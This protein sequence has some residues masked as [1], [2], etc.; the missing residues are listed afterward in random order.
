M[1][2]Q[3]TQ[4]SV[5]PGPLGGEGSSETRAEGVL[6]S[7]YC[8]GLLGLTPFGGSWRLRRTLLTSSLRGR[9]WGIYPLTPISHWSPPHHTH[10]PP[11]PQTQM[12]SRVL[13][14]SPQSPLRAVATVRPTRGSGRT[15]SYNR[16]RKAMKV[17][18]L[19]L[20]FSDLCVYQY[21]PNTLAIPHPST[22]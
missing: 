15:S 19:H 6:M 14:A 20:L 3:V 5:V 2:V 13:A 17:G 7:S 16:T 10:L 4:M 1:L 22:D 9:S 12:G 11:L 8:C 18:Q 21:L